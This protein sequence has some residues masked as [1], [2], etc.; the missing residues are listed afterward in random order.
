MYAVAISICETIPDAFNGI[1]E[2]AIGKLR[3]PDAIQY[4][5]KN[6]ISAFH[7]NI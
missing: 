6:I 5:T 3:I 1:T 4:K 2:S 7:Q